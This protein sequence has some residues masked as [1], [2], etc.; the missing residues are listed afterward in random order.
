MSSIY[1]IPSSVGIAEMCQTHKRKRTNKRAN[2]LILSKSKEKSIPRCIQKQP[3]LWGWEEGRSCVKCAA[4]YIKQDL[5]ALKRGK[6]QTSSQF[7]IRDVYF[8]H[9]PV[10]KCKGKTK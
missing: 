2:P 9:T 10:T 1:N 7:P 6:W 4:E 3:Y 5:T 8:G